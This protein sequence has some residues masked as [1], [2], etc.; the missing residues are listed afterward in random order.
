M[1]DRETTEMH[2]PPPPFAAPWLALWECAAI[3]GQASLEGL[4][5]LWGVRS[6]RGDSLA[7]LAAAMDR[8]MRTPAFLSLV[9]YRPNVFDAHR[10]L[11]LVRALAQLYCVNAF[12][13]AFGRSI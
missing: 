2:S 11:D 9:P 10:S 4:A 8:Q 5:G 13:S 1:P 3:W 6:P 12:G 7:A